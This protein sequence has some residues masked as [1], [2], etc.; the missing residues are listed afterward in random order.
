MGP[1]LPLHLCP[2]RSLWLHTGPPHPY[3]LS[4]AVLRSAAGLSPPC[5]G[6][7]QGC[8]APT[9]SRPTTLPNSTTGLEALDPR[10]PSLS[11]GCI[12]WHLR[13]MLQ[14]HW[15]SFSPF[16]SQSIQRRLLLSTH[17]GH[18]VANTSASR[19]AEPVSASLA[20]AATFH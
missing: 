9:G 12:S 6:S 5:A 11:P 1:R 19:G 2:G 17:S 3:C 14:C 4:L 16:F 18:R 10:F 7:T 8:S 13:E 20:A 15:T